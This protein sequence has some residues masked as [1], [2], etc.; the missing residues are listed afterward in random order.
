MPKE[1]FTPYQRIILKAL[2]AA[3]GKIVPYAELNRLIGRQDESPG[4]SDSLKTQI[5]R[6]RDEHPWIEIRT[7]RNVGFSLGLDVCFECGQKLPEVTDEE[8]D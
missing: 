4:C 7:V 1:K 3:K 5:F 6:I 2:L 8:P